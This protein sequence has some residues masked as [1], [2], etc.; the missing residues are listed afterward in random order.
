MR[1]R[2]MTEEQNLLFEFIDDLLW[3]E[4]DPIGINGC[5]PRDEYESYVPQVFNLAI[6]NA[7]AEQIADRLHCL[8][9]ETIGVAGDFE[10]CK[11]LARIIVQ[12]K[13]VLLNGSSGT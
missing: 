3:Y 12:K 8:E 13:E 10:K 2:R 7:T 1:M 6:G 9:T 4:W 5:G 11:R